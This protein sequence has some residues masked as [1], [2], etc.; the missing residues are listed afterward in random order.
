M[1]PQF[2]N[3]KETPIL[4]VDADA[5]FPSVEQLMEPKYRGKP[6]IVGGW[7][8]GVVSSASYEARQFGVHSAMPIYEA[9]KLCPQG[10]FLRGNHRLYSHFSHNMFEIFKRFTPV[11]EMTSID[12]GYL[13]LSGTRQMHGID[14]F[15]IAS[16]ILGAV[17]KELGITISG[18]LSTTKMTSK[19]ASSLYKPRRLT[20]VWAG[21]ERGFLGA[22][23]LKAMPGI[24][25]KTI[26]KLSRL[27][28]GTLGD[29]AEVP[30]ETMWHLMGEHGIH[31]WERANGIDRRSVHPEAYKRKS[32][33]EEKT[34]PIDIDS[35]ELLI[36]EAHHMLKELCYQLR[37]DNLYAKTLTLKIRYKDFKTFTFQRTLEQVSS[38]P[39]DFLD[40]LHQL[41]KRRES[42][43]RVRL[44]GV[45][46]SHLKNDVQLGM[47]GSSSTSGVLAKCLPE[48]RHQLE[49]RL[50]ALR[51][52]YGKGII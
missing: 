31:L 13:D 12:E 20:W 29:L 17:K 39:N 51:E 5:F 38:L 33:S 26:P 27:G 9:R 2:V 19:I 10:I 50:D 42:K 14:Y 3:P 23:P 4:H 6:V 8:R 32:I 18:G 43:Q 28:L 44:I 36:K 25:P 11:V 46:L 41:F 52:K 22:L 34:F 47:F 35:Q 21:R 24:G 15:G 30:F 16:C 40:D 37:R 49:V 7:H 45:G 1:R 48:K